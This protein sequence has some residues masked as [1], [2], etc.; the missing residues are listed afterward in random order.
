[1][2]TVSVITPA[3][4]SSAT[5]LDCLSSV[6]NQSVQPEH[7]II[8][9][10]STDETLELINAYEGHT[11]HVYSQKDENL[12]DAINRG[13][14][15]ATGDVIGILN[16]DDYFA[17]P[18]VIEKVSEIFMGETIDGCYGDLCYVDREDTDKIVRY[19]RSGSFNKQKYYWGWMIPHPTFYV[20]KRIYE[21]FGDYRIDFGSAADY[22]LMLRLLV[23]NNLKV[24]Y[25]P[26]IMVNMRVGGVSNQSLQNRLA[27]NRRDRLAWKVNGLKPYPWTH[28]LKPLRKLPQWF[29]T[30]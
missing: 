16:S 2:V 27:A 13:I 23:K 9:G 19:W 6:S 18:E 11:P 24:R 28:V 20:R 29:V 5:I 3:L 4:N 30:P 26:E 10:E 15:H 22:E 25:L 12:Y 8:D 17:S 14:K 21:Q 7:I 1:M